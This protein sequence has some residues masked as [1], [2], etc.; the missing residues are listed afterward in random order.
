MQTGERSSTASG[1][2]LITG[3]EDGQA[4]EIIV[5]AISYLPKVLKKYALDS[6][7]TNGSRLC[8]M[9]VQ[10]HWNQTMPDLLFVPGSLA[11]KQ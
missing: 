8:L 7:R 1:E 6:G 4:V 5:D 3:R 11:T 2:F 10:F 9:E